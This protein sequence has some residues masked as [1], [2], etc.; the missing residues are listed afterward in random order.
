RIFHGLRKSLPSKH[1]RN[2]SF[3]L[4]QRARPSKLQFPETH[5]CFRCQRSLSRRRFPVVL[6]IGAPSLCTVPMSPL[7]SSRA[8]LW[9]TPYLFPD[10]MIVLQT[11]PESIL[12]LDV[13]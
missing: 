2:P 1:C 7:H 3:R 4:T 11:F 12:S 9:I 5:Q 6:A 10:P 13:R 8:S